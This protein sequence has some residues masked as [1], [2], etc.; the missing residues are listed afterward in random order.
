[1]NILRFYGSCGHIEDKEI[2]NE[3]F[4]KWL[5][6]NTKY[7]VNADCIYWL[8][9]VWNHQQSKINDCENRIKAIIATQK[10]LLA[11]RFNEG[12]QCGLSESRRAIA[13]VQD[14]KNLYLEEN[15]RL[16]NLLLQTEAKMDKQTIE[17][18]AL[19]IF[20]IDTLDL[21]SDDYKDDLIKAYSLQGLD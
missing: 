14:A 13:D 8:E 12:L 17:L 21:Y 16:T 18:E 3:E 10:T 4:E 7:I 11:T 9:E 1:M 6:E 19:R 2:S 5:D 20:A 15:E